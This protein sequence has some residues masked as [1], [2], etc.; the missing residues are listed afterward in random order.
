MREGDHLRDLGVDRII[1]RWIFGKWGVAVW[2][3]LIWLMMGTVGG[4]L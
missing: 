3:G 4:R 1:L 2:T